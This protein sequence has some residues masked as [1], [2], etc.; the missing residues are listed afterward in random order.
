MTI[1]RMCYRFGGAVNQQ[2]RE[3]LLRRRRFIGLGGG[4]SDALALAARAAAGPAGEGLVHRTTASALG[5]ELS[6]TVP[7]TADDMID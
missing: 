3:I 5:I 4:V 7:A 6:P 2:D 1:R